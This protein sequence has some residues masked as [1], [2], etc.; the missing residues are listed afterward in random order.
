MV[1]TSLMAGRT[2]R[3]DTAMTDEISL[4]GLVL[5]T[6]IQAGIAPSCFPRNRKDLEDVPEKTQSLSGASPIA[7][8][9]AS[10][11][12]RAFDP[13][14]LTNVSAAAGNQSMKLNVPP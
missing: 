7:V 8:V 5:L 11:R 13:L 4:R 1:L 2:I 3:T 14:K 9:I 6:A 12:R 10:S